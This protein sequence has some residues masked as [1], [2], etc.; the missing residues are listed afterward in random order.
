[1]DAMMRYLLILPMLLLGGCLGMGLQSMDAAQIRATEGMATCSQVYTVQGAARTVTVH[2][3]AAKKG[4]DST[5]EVII[6]PDCVV[7]VRGTGGGA[8]PV[9]VPTPQR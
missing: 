2:N 5:I 3:D 9:P 1:M 7:T 6:G 4:L 8:T